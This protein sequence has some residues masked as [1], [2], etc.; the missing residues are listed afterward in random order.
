MKPLIAAVLVSLSA[1][2]MAADEPEAVYAKYHRAAASGDLAELAKY[3]VA[4]QRSDMAGMSAAQKDAMVKMLAIT[5]PR[6]FVLRHKS[7]KPDGKSA[8]LI[9]SGPGASIGGEKP[10]TLFG[11]I[12]MA[13]ESGEWKVAESSWSNNPPAGLAE[14]PAPRGA[15]AKDAPQK[16]AAKAAAPTG[17]SNATPER[18]LGKAREP[19]VYKP[20]MTA[21]DMALCR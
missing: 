18:P 21:E 17:S 1:V 2:A 9:V 12:K 8:L 20:V 3:A 14:L 19:C 15:S 10:E 6:G 16:A 13:T 11:T 4:A 5:M 7:V